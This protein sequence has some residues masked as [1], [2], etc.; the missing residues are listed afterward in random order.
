M[1]EVKLIDNVIDGLKLINPTGG[2][3]RCDK[4]GSGLHNSSRGSR[5]HNG[6]DFAV[7]PGQDVLMPVSGKIVRE[8]YPYGN[9]SAWKG[10]YI[11][12]QRIE[13]KMWYLEP[14]PGRVGQHFSAGDVI[15]FAQDISKR[16][17]A[18][19]PHIHLRIVKVDPLLLFKVSG[20]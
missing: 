6:L 2:T 20:G 16:Y 3:I 14:L 1:T 10:L 5:L 12:N 8:S 11:W 17:Q 4:G 7:E 9:D 13:I 19:T 15:G 18:V